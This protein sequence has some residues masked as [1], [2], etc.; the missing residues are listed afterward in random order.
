MKL[1][2]HIDYLS[3][4][5]ISLI[6]FILKFG[7][8]VLNPSNT[9]WLLEVYHDWGQHFL[10]WSFYRNSPW[11]FPI[12]TN[13][14]WYYPIGTNVGITDSIP[15]FAIPFKL[16]SGILPID[17]QYF[18][19]WFL[20]CYILN[21]FFTIKLL[22]VFNVKNILILSTAVIIINTNPVLLF[23]T[24]HP[25]LCAQWLIIASFYFYF[26]PLEKGKYADKFALYHIILLIISG[27]IHPYLTLISLAFFFLYFVKNILISKVYDWKKGLFYF[28][29]GIIALL[30]IWFIVGILSF[31][32]TNLEVTNAYGLYSWN[33]NSFFNG[34]GFSK[35]FPQL[36]QKTWH[37]Y[38]GYSYL[39]VGGML[40]ICLAF[41]L[42]LPI[43]IIRKK[44]EKKTYLTYL[45]FSVTLLFFTGFAITN[46]VTYND[47]TLYELK[48][49][50]LI[51][52]LGNVFRAS[53]RYIW[54]IYYALLLFAIII[55]SRIKINQYIIGTL[56]IILAFVNIYDTSMF[57]T[58]DKYSD[59]KYEVPF[60]KVDFL[61]QVFS[62]VDHII[63]YP[64]YENSLENQ[65]DYQDFGYLAYKNN[66]K[67]TSAYVARTNGEEQVKFEQL[68][69][70]QLLEG[71]APE[72]SAF[73]T[74]IDYLDRFA[75]LINTGKF[76]IEKFGK[77]YIIYPK[78]IIN[79]QFDL[80]NFINQNLETKSKLFL[81]TFEKSILSQNRTENVKGNFD[82]ILVKEKVLLISGWAYIE[83]H[84]NPSITHTKF[85]LKDML[86]NEFV[87]DAKISD[88]NDIMEI[89]K[90]DSAMLKTGAQG[91]FKINNLKPG[92]Y[93]LS[94]VIEDENNILHSSDIQQTISIGTNEILL[95]ILTKNVSNNTTVKASIDTIEK[96]KD[97][98]NSFKINGW[99]A[100]ENRDN[101][102]TKVEIILK[103]DNQLYAIK[104]YKSSRPDLKE[105][106]P[107]EKNI[108]FA[109]FKTEFSIAKLPK[110]KYAVGLR[111]ISDDAK[112]VNIT[113]YNELVVK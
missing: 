58:N 104:T 60:E 113:F 109:G 90:G 107:N 59:G 17:F 101:E 106:F 26:K 5:I 86:N 97:K 31:D 68:I 7:L 71:K 1:K 64:P 36:P 27:L 10:G 94:I 102:K 25:S 6:I 96:D 16:I 28:L 32:S 74:K 56:L 111:T 50:E 80:N 42:T 44:I 14:E 48:A 77:Y 67:I 83:G 84:K 43:L 13:S 66:C 78:E 70:K 110:G 100:I 57:F 19:L 3:G 2:L 85:V 108:Q 103:K 52:K 55:I 29:S 88:R 45:L 53:A 51:I 76:A 30:F 47:Q 21:G 38:E 61:N 79:Q 62:K 20:V 82:E 12:G 35:Y 49:P 73:I 92:D 15:L 112:L 46:I 23:R 89:F 8:H 37:Q 39:G 41:V 81:A 69:N 22:K 4:F 93:N 63:M 75:L 91:V 105:A 34:G 98:E 24:L 40:M 18:G 95:P 33:L 99:S 72:K 11:T 9:K 65:N 87:V 54:V